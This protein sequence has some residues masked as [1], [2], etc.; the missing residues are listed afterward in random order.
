MFC[1]VGPVSGLYHN[2]RLPS[3]SRDHG[4]VPLVGVS[5]W[6]AVPV[7]TVQAQSRVTVSSSAAAPM[8][9][10]QKGCLLSLIVFTKKSRKLLPEL[11]CVASRN[12]P[13]EKNIFLPS[14]STVSSA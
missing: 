1:S 8:G 4:C 9:W 2:C 10:F 14:K 6:G 12:K 3:I 7:V 13:P 11:W 5:V